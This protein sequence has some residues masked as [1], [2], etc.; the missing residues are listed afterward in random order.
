MPY[1]RLNVRLNKIRGRGDARII[2]QPTRDND[3]T[4]IV[5]IRDTNRGPS[6]YE[7]ELS[8]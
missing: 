3:F 7:F 6:E 1:R 5:E 4:T 2:Q 8:W